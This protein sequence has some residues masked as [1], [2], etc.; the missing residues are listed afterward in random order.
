MLIRG[1]FS[2]LTDLASQI[3]ATVK[4]VEQ[5]MDTWQSTAGATSADWLDGAGGKFGEVSAAWQQVSTAQQAMLQAL[6]GGVDTSNNELQ[7]ALSSAVSRVGST[8]I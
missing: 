7:Q 1:N 4:K 2:Q 3:M 6:R 8:S 5:E